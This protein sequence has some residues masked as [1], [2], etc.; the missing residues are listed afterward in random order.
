MNKLKQIIT[1]THPFH[2]KYSQQYELINYKKSWGHECVDLYHVKE[3]HITVPIAWTDAA[4]PD[5]L[6][7]ISADRSYF[8]TDDL[9]RLVLLVE[10]IKQRINKMQTKNSVK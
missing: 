4:D 7:L 10:E 8:R 1:I 9:V 3:G 5:P 6:V 2:P